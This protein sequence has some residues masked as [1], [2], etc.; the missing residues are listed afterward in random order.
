MEQELAE[1]SKLR[2]EERQRWAEQAEELAALRT[3]LQAQDGERAEAAARQESE[4]VSLREA[5]RSS[6]EEVARLEREL[7]LS[8]DAELAAVQASERDR[9][10]V[11]RLE[12]ELA[13]TREADVH[14]AERERSEVE[15]LEREVA[16]LR[17]GQEDVWR[18]LRTL[19]ADGVEEALAPADPSLILDTV[20]SIKTR[21]MT[22]K[23]KQTESQDR[24]TELASTMETLQGK[25]LVCVSLVWSDS[26]CQKLKLL[27]IT[28]TLSRLI[29]RTTR[30]KNHRARRGFRQ[31]RA[32]GAA[33]CYG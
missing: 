13:A 16:S 12:S 29:C 19:A 4:L 2:E 33:D 24:C 17:D 8:K 7:A 26:L 18:H 10:E 23:E 5:E 22:L 30:Q 1:A 21:L 15:K 32:A 9:A 31:D 14:A 25:R 3:A 6:Q 27:L 20:Q 11:T 28:V